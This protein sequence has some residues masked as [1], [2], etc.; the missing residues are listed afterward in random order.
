MKIDVITRPNVHSD[1]YL[2]VEAV[3]GSQDGSNSHRLN[4][5]GNLGATIALWARIAQ[6]V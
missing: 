3:M 6:N 2:Q 1:E 4:L 5:S